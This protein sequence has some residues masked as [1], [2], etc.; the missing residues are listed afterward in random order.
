M[1][2][3]ICTIFNV[4][5]FFLMKHVGYGYITI[6]KYLFLLNMLIIT[7]FHDYKTKIIPNKYVLIMLVARCGFLV[8]ECLL[9][10]EVY[11]SILLLS[12]LGLL[13]GSGCFLLA[14]ALMRGSVGMGDIKL[15]GVVGFYVGIRKIFS[16]MLLSLIISSIVLI[17]MIIMKKIK[18]KDSVP[19]APFIAVGTYITLIFNL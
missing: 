2:Y 6:C 14:Y 5:S 13:V 3:F 11:K 15:I 12:F 7:A 10:T 19:F 16:C 17:V 18:S 9:N 4:L 8:I 1:K